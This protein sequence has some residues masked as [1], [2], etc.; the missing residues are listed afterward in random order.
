MVLIIFEIYQVAPENALISNK[1]HNIHHNMYLILYAFA[2]LFHL[3]LT[4][5][6]GE[7]NQNDKKAQ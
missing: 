5:Y 1:F 6:Q 3:S 2:V 7:L 4:H